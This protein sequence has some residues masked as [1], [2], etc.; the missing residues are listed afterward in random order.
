MMFAAGNC[1]YR[2]DESKVVVNDYSMKEQLMI[3]ILYLF[4][5]LLVLHSKKNKNDHEQ[6]LLMI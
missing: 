3:P 1:N 6:V 5:E 4:V 2:L